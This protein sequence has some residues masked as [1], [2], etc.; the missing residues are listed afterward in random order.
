MENGGFIN[1]YR[2]IMDEPSYFSERFCRN[3]AWIDLLLLANHAKGYYSV[4]G[5]RIEVL[6]GQVGWGIDKISQRWKWSR[7]K[8]ERFLNE[9]ETD[10]QI[11]RQKSNVT[12]LITINNYEKYQKYS[13]AN[14]QQTVKQTDI[15]KKKD[16]KRKE[17][18][19]KEESKKS[20]TEL[21]NRTETDP[22]KNTKWKV[23]DQMCQDGWIDKIL[24]SSYAKGC[25]RSIIISKLKEFIEIQHT[26]DKL[27]RNIPDLKQHF[28]NWFKKEIIRD[29]QVT[30]IM[31]VN[32]N[33]TN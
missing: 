27:D 25:Q 1:V 8:V 13:N 19:R 28:V 4:R 12:T 20:K 30:Y 9:L 24:S 17:L 29:K 31:P 14:G 15:N 18:I 2:K 7:G 11:V 32:N 3:M 26:T 23:W 6:R 22:D 21:T 16:T 33:D 5:V 10:R